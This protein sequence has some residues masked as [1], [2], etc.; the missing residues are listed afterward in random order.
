PMDVMS[1]NL[2]PGG[3]THPTPFATVA[4]NRYAAGWF[5]PDQV[6]VHASGSRTVDLLTP[7]SGTQMVVIRDRGGSY[8]ALTARVRSTYDPIPAAWQGVTVHRVTPHEFEESEDNVLGFR[9]VSQ[10]PATSYEVHDVN[11]SRPLDHV[12]APGTS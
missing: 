3:Y 5:G 1:G 8:F 6:V 7:G 2:G 10:W 4:I 9:S 11:G 12:I